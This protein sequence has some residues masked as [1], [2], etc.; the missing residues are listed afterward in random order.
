MAT[1]CSFLLYPGTYLGVYSS[2]LPV[3]MFFCCDTG[4]SFQSLLYVGLN[5]SNSRYMCPVKPVSMLKPTMAQTGRF[6]WRCGTGRAHRPMCSTTVSGLSM[7]GTM[8]FKSTDHLTANRT[9]LLSLKL[10]VCNFPF[11]RSVNICSFCNFPSVS[12]GTVYLFWL[13]R[14][15]FHIHC[16]FSR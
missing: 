4:I 7:N 13:K 15:F 12:L 1:C 8:S 5:L 6:L 2:L 16:P 11:P 10:S 14:Y 9:C 3:T